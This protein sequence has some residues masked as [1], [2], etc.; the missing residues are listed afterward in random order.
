MEYC[1]Q[2]IKNLPLQNV[3]KQGQFCQ[4]AVSEVYN[5]LDYKRTVNKKLVK[6]LIKKI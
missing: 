6:L 3:L 5:R 2:G 4:C 1:L